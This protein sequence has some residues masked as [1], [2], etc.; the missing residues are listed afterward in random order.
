MR[1]S[2]GN[3]AEEL[4]R[5]RHLSLVAT[6]WPR[7]FRRPALEWKL[8]REQGDNTA[9]SRDVSNDRR[10]NFGRDGGWEAPPESRGPTESRVLWRRCRDAL[11]SSKTVPPKILFAS[12]PLHLEFVR[13]GAA[14]AAPEIETLHAFCDRALHECPVN[15]HVRGFAVEFAQRGC[16]CHLE[17]VAE[18]EAAAS[19]DRLPSEIRTTKPAVVRKSIRNLAEKHER[20]RWRSQ[21]SHVTRKDLEKGLELVVAEHDR[22]SFLLR[23]S[24]L[25]PQ[26]RAETFEELVGGRSTVIFR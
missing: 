25:T 10:P 14:R 16:P 20:L 12:A 22:D 24:D 19:S 26:L 6:Q 15:Q 18:A 13:A 8:V 5:Q 21:V 23:A 9:T 1:Q 4:L 17:L 3:D 2:L 7:R 11:C